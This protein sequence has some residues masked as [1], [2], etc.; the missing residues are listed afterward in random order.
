MA[1]TKI[2]LISSGT[3]DLLEDVP[4]SLNFAIADIRE[5]ENRNSNYSKTITIPG[6]KTNNRLFS[7]IFEIDIDCNFNPNKKADCIL[8]VDEIPQIRGYLQLLSITKLLDNKIEY[9]ICIKGNVGSIFASWGERYLTDLDFSSLNHTYNK[10][11]QIASW[12]GSAGSGYVYPMIE[13]GQN[14]TNGLSYD[15]TNFFPAIYVKEYLDTAFT[16]HGFTYE[17][18]FFNTPF[19][20]R[21]IVPYN[22]TKL[23]LSEAELNSRYFEAKRSADYI[24]D[25]LTSVVNS[26]FIAFPLNWFNTG[27]TTPIK[28]NINQDVSDVSNQFNTTSNLATITN[29]GYYTFT[30]TI[31]FNLSFSGLTA[32]STLP[33][34]NCINFYICSYDSNNNYV[35]TLGMTSAYLVSESI[36][37]GSTTG[38]YIV[39]VET[40]SIYVNAN[41]K[42]GTAFFYK[43]ITGLYGIYLG[44]AGSID[45]NILSA[46]TFKNRALNFGI[47]DGNAIDFNSLGIVQNIKIKDFFKS[48]ITMF[49][50]YIESDKSV[51]NKYYIEPRDNFYANG[52]TIDWTPKLATNLQLELKPMGSLTASRYTFKYK[53]DKD[54]YNS[55]AQNSYID[56][57]GTKYVD[58]TT[59]F[60]KSEKKIDIIFSPTPSARI[61]TTNRIIPHIISVNQQGQIV[62]PP[63]NCN[64]RILYYGGKKST[65]AWTYTSAV[66]GSSSETEYPYCGHVDIPTQPTFDLSFGVPREIYW[67]TNYYTN[68][69]LYNKYWKKYLEEITDKDSKIVT[70]Y[71]HLNPVDIHLLDFRNQFFVDGHLLRLNKIYDYNPLAN[72][73]TKC[74]FIRIKDAL[75]FVD[76]SDISIYGTGI[77]YNTG[78]EAPNTNIITSLWGSG[79]FTD[80]TAGNVIDTTVTYTWVGGNNNFVGSGVSNTTIFGSSGV[81]IMPGLTGVTV[82]NTNN[83]TITQAGTTWIN[84]VNFTDGISEQGIIATPGGGQA[85]AYQ[86]TKKFNLVETCATNGDSIKTVSAVLDA[87]Q[88]FK[89]VGAAS[90]NVFPKS[91]ERF[92]RGT[93][94]LAVDAPYPVASRNTLH[95]YCYEP[96]IWTD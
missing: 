66:S 7:H 32:P 65:S 2:E 55:K 10:A 52:T 25:T 59:D 94:L 84:G 63:E 45:I 93:T 69:N 95:V 24:A 6:S 53:E 71:F 78:D 35:S 50:L 92:R 46:S 90:M 5:P 61:G 75:P 57:Y 87:E 64:I 29:A 11:T 14:G 13:Y 73:L 58:I 28:I 30:A 60:V 42:I 70:G 54:Y 38:T 41:S 3:I 83:V 96:G 33:A 12:T 27:S 77:L 88:T 44:Q 26:D 72:D 19:F 81:T 23:Q 49:N 86:T 37:N 47:T 22:G 43:E 15:V 67:D 68:S 85:N 62:A 56:P 79:V 9:N 20:K 76:D 1:R 48:L 51:E 36:S 34:G 40:P 18:N 31:S 4:F 21:L 74:E 91:G 89:N 16:Q 80:P 17:S 8:Y 39:T 82:V